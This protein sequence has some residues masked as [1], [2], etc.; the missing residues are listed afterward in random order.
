MSN[1]EMSVINIPVD[2]S[3]KS[4]QCQ[5]KRIALDKQTHPIM[6]NKVD[7]QPLSLWFRYKCITIWSKFNIMQ[8]GDLI[9]YLKMQMLKFLI[10]YLMCSLEYV[11]L[12][13]AYLKF[14]FPNWLWAFFLN[15]CKYLLK[16]DFV[17]INRQTI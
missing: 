14:Q 10:A 15:D 4:A 8:Y 12:P 17:K 7:L 5:T 13:F 9:F 11:Q 3:Y 16:L 2:C 1:Q 6:L